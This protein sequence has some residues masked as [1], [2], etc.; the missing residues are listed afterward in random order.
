MKSTN[1]VAS[2]L[3]EI[4]RKDVFSDIETGPRNPFPEDVVA[5]VALR[6]P[7]QKWSVWTALRQ[8]ESHPSDMR[9]WRGTLVSAIRLNP[10]LR[11]GLIKSEA[12]VA[13]A[14]MVMLT[15]KPYF[16]CVRS[17]PAIAAAT[18]PVQLACQEIKFLRLDLQV[19]YSNARSLNEFWWHDSKVWY[20]DD[21]PVIA[22]KETCQ[23]LIKS[24]KNGESKALR[25]Y[26][27]TRPTWNAE[28][29]SIA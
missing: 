27:L 11:Q 21:S 17:D 15:R 9:A 14:A 23:L 1:L 4:L 6:K 8:T 10:P 5:V 16:L 25:Y 3:Y 20:Q 12:V 13:A 19:K 26:I 2:R 7:S 28:I 22:T 24:W 18:G 29:P